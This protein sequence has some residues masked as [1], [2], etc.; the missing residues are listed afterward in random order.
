VSDFILNTK[1]KMEKTVEVYK[2]DLS[3]IRTGRANPAMVE[4]IKV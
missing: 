3:Q 2:K 4:D 1:T